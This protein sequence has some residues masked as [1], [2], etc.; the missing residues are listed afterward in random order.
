MYSVIKF[1]IFRTSSLP[2]TSSQDETALQFHP[3]C[4]EAVISNLLVTYQCRMYRRKLL[5]MGTEYA[6]NM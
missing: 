1:Y 5:M 3:D 6:R 2:V 4:L